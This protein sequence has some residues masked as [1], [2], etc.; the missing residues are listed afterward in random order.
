MEVIAIWTELTCEVH[1]CPKTEIAFRT[2]QLTAYLAHA[3][4]GHVP[5]PGFRQTM[6]NSASWIASSRCRNRRAPAPPFQDDKSQST[7]SQT[8]SETPPAKF[9]SSRVPEKTLLAPRHTR[10]QNQRPTQP[11]GACSPLLTEE[12]KKRLRVEGIWNHLRQ[13][14]AT[15]EQ[16]GQ[17]VWKG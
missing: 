11:V 1:H 5:R 4:I 12:K 8:H 2:R 9:S 16:Q 17:R 15:R 7:R 6:E 3:Q 13:H 10:V 14:R